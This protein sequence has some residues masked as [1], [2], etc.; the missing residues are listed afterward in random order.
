MDGTG[1]NHISLVQSLSDNCI[2]Q[3][4]SKDAEN[5]RPW[6]MLLTQLHR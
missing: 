2:R 3:R 6:L 4:A 5:G 1:L